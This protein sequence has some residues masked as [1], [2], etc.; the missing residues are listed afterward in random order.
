MKVDR[1]CLCIADLAKVSPYMAVT[2]VR[3]GP[4][5][6]AP[7]GVPAHLVRAPPRCDCRAAA[8]GVDWGRSV[9]CW[10]GGG[11]YKPAFWRDRAEK[12]F[13]E[14]EVARQ[15]DGDGAVAQVCGQCDPLFGLP[16]EFVCSTLPSNDIVGSGPMVC[17]VFR[18][19][20]WAYGRA[21][22]DH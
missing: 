18:A 16:R 12:R 17:V 14:V 13:V 5:R 22:Q 2:H 7:C 1:L 9:Q 8:L 15:G 11:G 6:A 4:I 19:I 10:R 20:Q 21:F 3:P